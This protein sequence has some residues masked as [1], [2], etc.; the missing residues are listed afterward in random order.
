MAQKRTVAQRVSAL[1]DRKKARFPR[2]WPRVV[3]SYMAKEE[4]EN[5]KMLFQKFGVKY[6]GE[7]KRLRVAYKIP[8]GIEFDVQNPASCPKAGTWNGFL[9]CFK[10]VWSQSTLEEKTDFVETMMERTSPQRN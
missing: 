5:C 10:D 4:R 3:R 2:C 7:K 6:W 8:W 1:L 9:E